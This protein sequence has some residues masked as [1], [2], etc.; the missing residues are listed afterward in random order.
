[1]K[2]LVLLAPL[3]L[4]LERG[5]A[6]NPTPMQEAGKLNLNFDMNQLGGLAL[7]Y[8]LSLYP[9]AMLHFRWSIDT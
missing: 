2:Q 7:G 4:G 9:Y 8:V 5:L 6:Q 1:M 3:L